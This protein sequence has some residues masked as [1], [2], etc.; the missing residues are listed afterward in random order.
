M[1][2]I[3]SATGKVRFSVP[4][5]AAPGVPGRSIRARLRYD[6]GVREEVTTWNAEMPTGSVGLGWTFTWPQIIRRPQLS[7]A[8]TED[9][10][11]LLGDDDQQ[12]ALRLSAVHPDGT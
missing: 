2:L 4:L 7:G 11:V 3:N 1:T 6:S 12:F 9:T 10:Y 8:P 5:V